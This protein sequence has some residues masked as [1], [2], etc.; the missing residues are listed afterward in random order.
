MLC[1]LLDFSDNAISTLSPL[2]LTGYISS[3]HREGRL[4]LDFHSNRLTEI[5]PGLLAGSGSTV[6]SHL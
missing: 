5:P 3:V 6:I 1:S 4:V 2:F